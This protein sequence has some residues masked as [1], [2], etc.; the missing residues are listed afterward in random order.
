MIQNAGL[1]TVNLLLNT[2]QVKQADTLIELMQT[3]LKL[4]SETFTSDEDD[5]PELTSIGPKEKMSKTLDTFKGMFKLYKIRSNVM[6]GKN[7]LIPNEE[8]SEI[9]IL[10]GHQYYN[11]IDYQMAAK[12]LSKKFINP[13]SNLK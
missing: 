11:G 1:L 8:I 5:D 6:N 9:S 7:M 3:R 12:E 10:K 2:N 4:S 13:L